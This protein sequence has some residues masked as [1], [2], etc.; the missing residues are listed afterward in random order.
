MIEPAGLEVRDLPVAG[1]RPWGR[2]PRRITRERLAALGR[3]L[4]A[5]PEMLRARPLIALPDGTVIAGNQRLAAAIEL[6]WETVPTVVVDLDEARAAEWAL[7]DN[8][9]YGTDIEDDVS[10][11]LAELAAAG[12]D[13]ELTGFDTADLDRLLQPVAF[14]ADPDELP[15]LPEGKP[16]SR[17]GQVYKLGAHRLMC[18]DATNPK[19]VA[20]LLAGAEPLLL[21]TDPPYGI[22]YDA[23]WRDGVHNDLGPAEPNSGHYLRQRAEGH[24]NTTMSGDTRADWSDCYA[25]LPSLTVAYVWHA[26]RH[27]AAVEA[28]LERI[29]FEVVQQIIWDKGLFAMGR[30]SYH[31][32]HEPCWYARRKGSKVPW[33][34]GFKQSTVWQAASPKMIMG[35]SDEE[36][37][38]HPTQKPAVLFTRVLENHLKRGEGVYDPFGGSGTTLIAAQQTGR[39]AYLM[40][41]EPFFCDVIRDRYV[42]FVKAAAGGEG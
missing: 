10:V 3:A 7:R 5:E 19:Y 36:K 32:Q 25:L 33:Y 35:G 40:E 6:G 8:R 23:R 18:G 9:P 1:L 26:S 13:L 31:W 4:A 24:R 20:K 27:A 16:R 11:L 28:G 17:P 37:H 21:A 39:V 30:Q 15:P 2:N 22:E 41:I 14:A 29:G 38:D 34:G 42:A 12:R